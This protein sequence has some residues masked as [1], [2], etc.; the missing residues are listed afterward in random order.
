MTRILDD[1]LTKQHGQKFEEA[2][3][4][5]VAFGGEE[6]NELLFPIEVDGILYK[7]AIKDHGSDLL[8]VENAIREFCIK[9]NVDIDSV[10]K[11][12]TKLRN[13]VLAL[14]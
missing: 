13:S 7:T 1:Y 2:S 6:K 8:E 3:V 4:A 9:A 14:T 5:L 11:Y 12:F 10:D